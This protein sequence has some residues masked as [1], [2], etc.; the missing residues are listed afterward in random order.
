MSLFTE[1]SLPAPGRA[2]LAVGKNGQ[3][4]RREFPS[5]DSRPF[6]KMDPIRYTPECAVFEGE[7][8]PPWN[9]TQVLFGSGREAV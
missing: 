4:K 7:E 3:G 9:P 1:M 6:G 5:Q 2:A 8:V